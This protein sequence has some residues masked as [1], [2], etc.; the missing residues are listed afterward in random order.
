MKKELEEDPTAPNRRQQA[1]RERAARERAERL[2]RALE[3]LKEIEKNMEARQK[4]SSTKARASSSDPEARK[5]K[6][7]D[8]GFRPAYNV[9]FTSDDSGIIVACDVTNQGTDAGLLEPMVAEIKD[10][11]GQAP[12]KHLA[13]GGFSTVKDIEAVQSQHD[14]KVYT[15]VKDVDKKRQA[16]IDPF[17]RLDN[18]S[19]EVGEWRQRMGTPEAQQ[20]YQRRGEIAEWVNARARQRGMQQW[21]VR[22][23]AKVYVVVLWHVLAHNL[24]HA[25]T[26]RERQG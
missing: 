10:K 26:L 13:D 20:T 16:G 9:Q 21:T 12:Q 25:R 6:M 15:P 3:N 5:M 18:D 1:A 2:Q 24:V 7:P 23:R 19:D 17:A 14:T 11:L 4:G 22:S 8:G